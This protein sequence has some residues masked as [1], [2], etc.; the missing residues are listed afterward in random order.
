MREVGLHP[1]VLMELSPASSTVQKSKNLTCTPIQSVLNAN[2][3]HFY[4]DIVTFSLIEAPF[5]V[6]RLHIQ[7]R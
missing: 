4:L 3:G 7:G 6:I 1:E 2:S 5:A